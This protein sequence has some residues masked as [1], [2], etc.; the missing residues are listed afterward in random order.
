MSRVAV[1][2]ELIRWAR[3]RSGFAESI[4]AERFPKYVEWESGKTQPTLRQLED[5]AKKTMTPF[6][7]FFLPEPPEEQL[8]IPDFRTLRDQ[9]LRRPSPN[10]LETIHTMQRRQDWLRDYLVEEAADALSFIGSVTLESSPREAARRIREAVGM[11]S[12]WARE[13]ATWTA[14]LL[15]LRRSIEAIGVMVVINGVVGNN[16]TRKLD[17][18]E[19]RGFVLSDRY[20]PLIFVNGA[21]FKS[22]QM[23]TLAHELAHLWLGRDGVF[24]FLD[25]Q[26]GNSDV[27]RFCNAVAAEVLIPS[28]ELRDSWR[29]VARAAD[30]FQAL[31]SRFKVSPIVA[32]RRA[33]DLQ[34][35]QREAFFSF[36]R[37]YKQN[38]ERKAAAKKSGGDFYLTQEVR[39]GRRFGEAIIRAARDG[40]LLYR[41]AYRLTGLSGTTFDRFA[42][43]LGFRDS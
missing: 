33:L 15:G 31:A 26:P 14:A 9:P 13:H 39:I 6:G 25:L 3:E 23:F 5:L 28:T 11:T 35:I 16:N 27:E 41:D 19:F 24:D 8:P 43:G 32:A 38:E 10:L 40:R 37:D 34:L 20:A 1:K 36:L 12:G 42:E 18:E 7:Y 4:L 21:D 17:P 2:P 29:Y 22:A 30:P